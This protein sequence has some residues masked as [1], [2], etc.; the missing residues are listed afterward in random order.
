MTIYIFSTQS[1]YSEEHL[2]G[3]LFDDLRELLQLNLLPL[4]KDL[5]DQSVNLLLRLDPVYKELPKSF[6]M[7]LEH[8]RRH[9]GS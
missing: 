7:I 8:T 3:D 6:K 4:S 5:L 9:L 1:A 2:G